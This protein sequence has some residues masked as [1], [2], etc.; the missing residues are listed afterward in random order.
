MSDKS[1]YENLTQLGGKSELPHS[2][3]A[4]V[5]EKVPNPQ[6]G[7]NY[8]VRFTA[9]EFTSL[10]PITGAPD[11]AHLMIDYVPG[12]W[13]VESKSLKLFLGSF[14]NHGAFHEDCTVSIGKRLVDLLEPVWLRIGGYWYP[15]GGIPID[16]FYQTGPAPGD[17]WVPDQ[18]VPP[19]RGRG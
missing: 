9:P 2:P 15:R 13:L 10:C 4:A 11:F 1:I 8:L 12:D 17:V 7:T 16:V 3:E 6:A 18:G 14:R 19:Y 5:L